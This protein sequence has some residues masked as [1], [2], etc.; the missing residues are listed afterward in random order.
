M[1]LKILIIFLRLIYKNLP[2]KAYPVF[3][4]QNYKKPRE[5]NGRIICAN[6][7]LAQSLIKLKIPQAIFPNT[8]F[9]TKSIISYNRQLKQILRNGK[10]GKLNVGIVLILPEGFQLVPPNQISKRNKKKIVNLY[11][12][13][14]NRRYKNILVMGPIPGNQYQNIIYPIIVPNLI[15]QKK[16]NYGKSIIYL[17]RNH[18]RG[19]IYPDGSK[20]NNTT[21]IASVIGVVKNIFMVEKKGFHIVVEITIGSC[22]IEKVPLGPKLIV[23]LGQKIYI[24]ESITINPNIGG[25][26][27]IDKEIVLQY[28]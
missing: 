12:Q 13:P 22:I 15:L 24:D 9:I 2:S 16:V 3:A 28:L 25:F 18:G 27:Q 14:Y 5:E 11:Y 19:Q 6:C 17:G 8:V 1:Y 23:H 10:L 20:S 21:Y 4:Q 26:G 7:H